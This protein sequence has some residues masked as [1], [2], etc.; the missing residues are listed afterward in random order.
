MQVG[1]VCGLTAAHSYEFNKEA[2][3]PVIHLMADQKDITQMGGTMRLGSYPAVLAE[4]SRI[5]EIYNTAEISERHRHRFE[6]NNTYRDTFTK[7]GLT[8]PGLSPDGKLVETI[9][10]AEHPW[11][12]GVQYHPEL[13]SRPLAPHPLF[14]EF[15]RATVEYRC[16]REIAVPSEQ[17]ADR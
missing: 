6:V 16:A 3:H 14:R 5:R 11:F 4:G 10:I 2:E 12:V 7:S 9:E 8:L 15:V 13:K 1:K 17:P